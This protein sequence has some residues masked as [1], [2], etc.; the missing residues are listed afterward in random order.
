MKRLVRYT[1]LS[2]TLLVL[3]FS[4]LNVYALYLTRQLPWQRPVFDYQRPADPGVVGNKGVLVFTKTNGFRHTESIAAGIATFQKEGEKRGWDVVCTENGAFFNTDYLSRFKVVVFHCT[5]GD[6]LTPEQ[7]KVLEAFVTNGGGFVG[8]HSAADTEYS[9][10]WYG[11]LV[12][13]YFRDHSMRPHQPEATIHTEDLKHPTTRHLPKTWRRADEWYNYKANPRGKGKI[14]VLASLDENSYDVGETKG[15]GADHP[16]S[17][18]NKV[19]KGRA[20]YTGMGHAGVMF[21][22]PLPLQH[23]LAAIEWTGRF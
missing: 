12:G 17:W 13:A 22:Q 20:F 4:A 6:V 7:E 15:M 3:L 23:I 8:I 11:Q 1:L 10:E 5:T 14:H 18:V 16:I 9:W 19:G 21:E 2:A